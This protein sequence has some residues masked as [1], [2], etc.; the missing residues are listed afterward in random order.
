MK[1]FINVLGCYYTSFDVF[2]VVMKLVV[3]SIVYLNS[4]CQDS[5]YVLS[6]PCNVV[7]LHSSIFGQTLPCLLRSVPVGSFR[8]DM[9]DPFSY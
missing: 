3:L 7:S 1:L 5:V 4:F 9:F 2:V 8:S 6:C